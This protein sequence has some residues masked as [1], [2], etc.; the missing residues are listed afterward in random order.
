MNDFSNIS[1]L[2]FEILRNSHFDKEEKCGDLLVHTC[3]C[4]MNFAI[5]FVLLSWVVVIDQ[6]YRISVC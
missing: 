6:I 5:Y 3:G 1:T 4:E 2:G